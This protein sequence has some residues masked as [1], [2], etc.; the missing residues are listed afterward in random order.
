MAP[1]F[2][3]E[4][5]AMVLESLSSRRDLIAFIGASKVFQ[6]AYSER[7]EKANAAI[8][9]NT[10]GDECALS[11]ALAIVRW[12]DIDQCEVDASLLDKIECHLISYIRG[13]EAIELRPVEFVAL[14]KL[15]ET[16][17]K[18]IDHFARTPISIHSAEGQQHMVYCAL[19]DVTQPPY[20]EHPPMSTSVE[21]ARSISAFC[22]YELFSRGSRAYIEH[23]GDDLRD[24]QGPDFYRSLKMLCLQERCVPGTFRPTRQWRDHL[25]KSVFISRRRLGLRRWHDLWRTP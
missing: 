15:H 6:Q 21:R 2:P 16:Y 1:H 22:R 12:S 7:R 17:S 20:L 25:D 24:P 19:S 5:W 13:N 10:F 3:C 9:Q 4:V 18:F 23:P 14:D 8:I 11:H